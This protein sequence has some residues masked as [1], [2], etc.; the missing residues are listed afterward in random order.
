VR[1]VVGAQAFFQIYGL[2]GELV[3]EYLWNGSTATL[4]KEYGY[5]DG[6]MLVV[7]ESATVRW[8]VTDHLG[9]PRILADQTG[10][11]SGISRHDYFPFGEENLLG[12]QRVGNG[13][14]ASILVSAIHVSMKHTDTGR[15]ARSCVST[16]ADGRNDDQGYHIHTDGADGISLYEPDFEFDELKKEYQPR[17]IDFVP[18]TDRI[19]LIVFGTGMQAKSKSNRF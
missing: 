14:S 9:T 11:L 8:L 3:A 2:G 5:R 16:I 19:Y 10:S 13:Y 7:A 12:A 4:Q 17:Q 1:R 6:E 18:E 15:D